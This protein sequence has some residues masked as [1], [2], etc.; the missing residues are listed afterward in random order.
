MAQSMDLKK[1]EIW[2][3]DK[4][5]LDYRY[6]FTRNE[7]KKMD[8]NTAKKALEIFTKTEYARSNG[9]LQVDLIGGEPLLEYKLITGLQEYR[10]NYESHT[11]KKLNFR[12]ITTGFMD[13]AKRQY[14]KKKKIALKSSLNSMEP[15][16]AWWYRVESGSDLPTPSM[17]ARIP[18][19]RKT[20]PDFQYRL[21]ISPKKP[22]IKSRIENLIGHRED[23][24]H[25]IPQHITYFEY[26]QF[27]DLRDSMQEYALWFKK[28]LLRKYIP[29][30]LNS[31][32]MLFLIHRFNE[33]RP[34]PIKNH[35]N[36]TYERVMLDVDGTFRT[37]RHFDLYPKWSLGNIDDGFYHPRRKSLYRYG[38]VIKNG[39]RKCIARFFCAGPCIS[40]AC[41][42]AESYIRPMGYHCLFTTL[43]TE[44][45]E[46]VYNSLK[47]ENPDILEWTLEQI[48]N[49]MGGQANL[50]S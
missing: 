34:Y 10:E 4:T 15:T 5:D 35:C 46:F 28:R 22:A 50:K 38:M 1:L 24:I 23:N 26:D 30:V 25:L 27:T 41:V 11:G 43:L 47:T 17:S 31:K 6:A 37:C 45:M 8:Y 16:D 9:D 48:G 39:C 18:I 7:G 2:M 13:D 3:G 44:N 29:P 32:R 33:G 21:V 40:T 49:P 19:I 12:L 14:F 36:N 20:F 42:Y